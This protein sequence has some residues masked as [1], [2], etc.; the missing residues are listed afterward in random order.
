[1]EG[2]GKT[3]SSPEEHQY[4]SP[5]QWQVSVKLLQLMQSDYQWA[6]KQLEDVCRTF[7]EREHVAS[8]HLCSVLEALDR[9]ADWGKDLTAMP[10]GRAIAPLPLR[11]N[12]LGSFEVR[13]GWKKVDSWHSL[14]AKSLLKYL[15][16]RG[17]RPVPKDVL[18]EAL[19]PECDSQAANNN[20]KTAVHALR[21]ILNPN[22][23][24]SNGKEGFFYVLFLEGNY[25]I[26]PQAELWVD[27]DEFERHWMASLRLD[28]EGKVDEA[29]RECQLAEMFYRG[30]FLEDNPY[31]E[32]TLLRREALKDIYL[33]I[34]S[35]L[36]ERSVKEEDYEGCIVYCQKILAKDPCREDAYRGLMRCHSRLGHRSRALN[37]YKL[38]V[39]TLRAEL[40]TLPDRQTAA[41]YNH[42]LK[43]E[44]I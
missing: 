38:C 37:W 1:M 15:V 32:W 4:G 11:A 10:G 25:M 20:L 19:W 17:G 2:A 39:R 34:L 43:D 23:K 24:E 5:H 14:K 44:P 22:G 30:D 28:K 33:A 7:G 21:Q 35:R 26:N 16:A 13:M 41:L 8:E 18:M 12:C 29:T 40:D 3:Y 27:V 6:R 31:E 36:G 9:V 42:L